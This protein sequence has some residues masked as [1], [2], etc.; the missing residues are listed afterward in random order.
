LRDRVLISGGRTYLVSAFLE[1][2]YKETADKIGGFLMRAEVTA[3]IE[4]AFFK[5]DDPLLQQI[6]LDAA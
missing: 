4:A 6:L 3:R 5:V 2:E 1:D